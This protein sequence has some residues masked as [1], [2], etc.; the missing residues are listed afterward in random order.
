MRDYDARMTGAVHKRF[1]KQLRNRSVILK[2]RSV[3]ALLRC[4]LPC[5][6]EAHRR[7]EPLPNKM[8]PA[9]IQTGFQARL[10]SQQSRSA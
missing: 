4:V 8:H 7:C 5:I 1:H 9:A 10:L 6:Q 3:I 2:I